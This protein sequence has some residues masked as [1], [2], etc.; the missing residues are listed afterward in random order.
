MVAALGRARPVWRRTVTTKKTSPQAP[1]RLP[2]HDFPSRWGGA[3]GRPACGVRFE[4][5][6]VKRRDDATAAAP[7]FR[8]ARERR[9]EAE[10]VQDIL[11]KSPGFYGNFE[12]V[13][14]FTISWIAGCFFVFRMGF[15]VRTSRLG[16]VDRQI[17]RRRRGIGALFIFYSNER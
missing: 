9:E 5:E 11:R 2:A 15:C 7:A 13:L 14:R 17:G 3:R 10:I 4:R 16:C 12:L 8:R 1:P 6:S